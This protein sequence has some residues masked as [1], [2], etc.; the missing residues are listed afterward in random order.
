MRNSMVTEIDSTG[1]T[2]LNEIGQTDS[3][4]VLIID[5]ISVLK[6]RA[7]NGYGR[8]NKITSTNV[9]PYLS[10]F[11]W[12]GYEYVKRPVILLAQRKGQRGSGRLL[13]RCD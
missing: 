5:P 4:T 10:Q 9:R 7:E 1:L 3:I 11:Q 13:Q 2:S 8:T 6:Y 12:L